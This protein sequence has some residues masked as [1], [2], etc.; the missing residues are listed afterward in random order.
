LCYAL[1]MQLALSILALY[2]LTLALLAAFLPWDS[3]LVLATANW[4]VSLML[5][6]V[7]AEEPKVPLTMPTP[8]GRLFVVP[9]PRDR[10]ISKTLVGSF[11]VLVLLTFVLLAAWMSWSEAV[12]L[13][14]LAWAMGAA[15]YKL[16]IVKLAGIETLSLKYWFDE[17]K[18]Q[19]KAA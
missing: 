13:T 15:I 4:I 2:L 10:Y 6:P 18:D 5:M 12:L 19:S 17:T 11:G 7:I 1:A 14:V 3:A 16:L 8:I 9:T